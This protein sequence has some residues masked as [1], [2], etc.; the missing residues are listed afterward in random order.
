MFRII[1]FLGNKMANFKENDQF[2]LYIAHRY[3]LQTQ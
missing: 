2:S 1:L 3:P